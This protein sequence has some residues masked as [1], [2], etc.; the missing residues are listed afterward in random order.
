MSMIFSKAQ[1]DSKNGIV[2]CFIGATIAQIKTTQ[3]CKRGDTLQIQINNGKPLVIGVI[4]RGDEMME[5]INENT[6]Q[7]KALN[8]RLHE[9]NEIVNKLNKE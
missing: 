2:E 8:K 6:K 1:N 7:I 4:G 5:Q 9:M 3:P